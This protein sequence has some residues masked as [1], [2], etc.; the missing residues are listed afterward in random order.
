MGGL[1]YGNGRPQRP[2]SYQIRDVCVRVN[3]VGQ[4][5]ATAASN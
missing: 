4:R 1:A 5:S 2:V 3:L